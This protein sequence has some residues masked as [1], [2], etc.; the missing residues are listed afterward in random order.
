MDPVTI[1]KYQKNISIL[2]FIRIQI[3]TKIFEI[4]K[5]HQIFYNEVDIISFTYTLQ[6]LC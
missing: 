2:F 5:N 3:F 6:I 1:L 4:T